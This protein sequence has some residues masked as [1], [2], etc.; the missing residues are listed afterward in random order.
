MDC[1]KGRKTRRRTAT[2][3]KV[4]GTMDEGRG[5][6]REFRMSNYELKELTGGI[7]RKLSG[8][9]WC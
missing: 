8:R 6:K 2:E 3:G 4:R 9:G 1:H 7:L 5:T